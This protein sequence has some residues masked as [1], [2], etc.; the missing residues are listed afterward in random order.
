MSHGS[1]S[2]RFP[3]GDRRAVRTF[4]PPALVSPLSLLKVESPISTGRHAY[5]Y[6]IWK[7]NHQGLLHTGGYYN[8]PPGKPPK[9]DRFSESVDRWWGGNMSPP[10]HLFLLSK[11]S[12][13]VLQWM[14]HGPINLN[15][16]NLAAMPPIKC[17]MVFSFYRSMCTDLDG[18][19]FCLG[20]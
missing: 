14:W 12:H 4:T 13:K 20:G 9:V 5:Y 1:R 6:T 15:V 2:N 7:T 17:D 10:P 19:I 11:C 16:L 3:P 18:C 8:H